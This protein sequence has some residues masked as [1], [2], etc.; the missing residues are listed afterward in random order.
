MDK[1]I[2]TVLDELKDLVV[3]EVDKMTQK[4]TLSVADLKTATDAV[5]LLTKIKMYEE[6]GGEY[7]PDGRS[8][9][10]WDGRRSPVTGK[11]ISRE[12]SNHSINDRMIAKLEEMY[13]DAVT[14]YEREEIRREIERLRK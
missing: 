10:M 5:H 13:D 7:D 12:H 4:G 11:Y 2:L 8:F 1:D 6:G 3:M 14:E 9:M